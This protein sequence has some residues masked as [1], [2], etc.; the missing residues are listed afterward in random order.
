MLHPFHAE[1]GD[2]G[3]RTIRADPAERAVVAAGD[4]AGRRRVGCE[5]E[6]GAVVHLDGA[7]GVAIGQGDE[8][9]G[10]VAQR[11]CHG[12]AAAIE[13]G[14]D[15]EGIQVLRNAAGF[16]QE[17]GG[18]LAHGTPFPTLPR[19]AGEGVL[20]LPLPRSGG[21]G[22]HLTSLRDGESPAD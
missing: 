15:H 9:Q 6:C 19:V 16:Q 4:E 10:A 20:P 14:G 7:P 12:R 1:L 11:E 5:R 8:A 18:G 17:L 21:R 3:Y 22:R 13:A 2:V